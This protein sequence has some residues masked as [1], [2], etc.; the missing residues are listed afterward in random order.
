MG[1]KVTYT[2]A[3]QTKAEHA[4]ARQEAYWAKRAG[5]VETRQATSAEMQARAKKRKDPK[6]A[7]PF[8]KLAKNESSTREAKSQ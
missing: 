2:Q 6:A 1:G 8:R 4:K 5:E 7:S 3:G